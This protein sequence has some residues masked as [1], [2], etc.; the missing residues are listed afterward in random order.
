[1]TGW[2]QDAAAGRPLDNKLQAGGLHEQ[3][4]IDGSCVAGRIV[5]HASRYRSPVILR[6][7]ALSSSDRALLSREAV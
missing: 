7:F 4:D 5:D 3:T 2:W 6:R 1:M